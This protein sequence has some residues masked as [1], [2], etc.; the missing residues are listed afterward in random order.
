MFDI[1]KILVIIGCAKSGTSALAH[2][3]SAHPDICLGQ[4]KEPMFFTNFGDK[5]WTGPATEGFQNSG[6]YDSADYVSNFANLHEDQWAL[7]ASTDYI[8]CKDTPDLLSAFAQSCDVR[9]ICVVRDPLD[10]AVLE[11]NHTLRQGWEDPSY[12]NSID[13]EEARRKLGWHPLFY[14]KRHSTVSH[15]IQRFADRF[16]D[17]FLVIDYSDL[18]DAQTLTN[19]ICV[20]LGI[21]EMPVS[22]IRQKNVS[23]IPRS[24]VAKILLKNSFLKKIGSA[25]LPA[26]V[27]KVIWNRLHTNARN[28]E[29]V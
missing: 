27:R 25:L 16:N 21:S 5:V 28:V 12:G 3:L 6:I 24:S 29:T 8:W 11:Y 7:D 13:A 22:E 18:S 2:H 10:R 9:V 26:A 4:Q 19:R 17:R 1:K 20:F 15:D 14:H 23:Y